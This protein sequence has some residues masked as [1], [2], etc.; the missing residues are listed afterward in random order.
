MT[1]VSIGISNNILLARLATSQAKP[2][3]SFHALSDPYSVSKLI[4][5]LDISALWGIGHATRKKAQAN[6]GTTILGEMQG[7]SQ[8][9]MSN[10]LGK[11]IGEMVYDAIRGVDRRK[12]ESDKPRKSVSAEINV[13]QYYNNLASTVNHYALVWHTI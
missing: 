12:I 7:K 2:A 3:G 13:R 6:L 10:A 11:S 5:P 8:Q 1:I 9:E 4:G